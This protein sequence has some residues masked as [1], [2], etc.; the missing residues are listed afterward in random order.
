MSK[1]SVLQEDAAFYGLFSRSLTEF[2]MC[3]TSMAFSDK[4]NEI[5]PGI[6]FFC[7]RSACSS[8]LACMLLG[9]MVDLET[10]LKC[11]I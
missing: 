4:S 9:S 8:S 1:L 6:K 7:L 11:T 3:D 2:E 10:Y 5:S